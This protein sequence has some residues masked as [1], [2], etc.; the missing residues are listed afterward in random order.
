LLAGCV[1]GNER[2]VALAVIFRSAVLELL[3]VEAHFD[4]D[5]LKFVGLS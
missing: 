3:C 4:E 5:K 2:A 1:K